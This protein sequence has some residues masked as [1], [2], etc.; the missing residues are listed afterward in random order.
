MN[1]EN[2]I[3]DAKRLIGQKFNDSK[4]QDDMKYFTYKV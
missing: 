2:T 4:V 1:P 3:Y